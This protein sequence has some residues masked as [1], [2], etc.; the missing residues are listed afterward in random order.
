M[1]NNKKKGKKSKGEVA[2]VRTELS[3]R[4]KMMLLDMHAILHRGYHALPDFRTRDGQPTGALYGLV[5]LLI[6][7]IKEVEPDFVIATY[8]LPAPTKRHKA[9]AWVILK[10]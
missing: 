5:S 10:L 6:S 4:D 9:F 1:M 8:D 3:G 7:A 2:G